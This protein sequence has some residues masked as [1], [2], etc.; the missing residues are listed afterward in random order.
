MSEY[1]AGTGI[2]RD[3]SEEEDLENVTVG[4]YGVVW[5]GDVFPVQSGSYAGEANVNIFMELAV[6]FFFV[7][8]LIILL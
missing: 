6:R 3:T 5:K 8:L 7:V 2:V 1:V 4:G